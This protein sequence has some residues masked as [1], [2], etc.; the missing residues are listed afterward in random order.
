MGFTNRSHSFEQIDVCAEQ[1][2]PWLTE[3]AGGSGRWVRPRERGEEAGVVV[4]P[5]LGWGLANTPVEIPCGVPLAVSGGQCL[6][7][8]SCW[9]AVDFTAAVSFILKHLFSLSFL[10]TKMNPFSKIL[11]RVQTAEPSGVCGNQDGAAA[12]R[13]AHPPSAS[14]LAGLTVPIAV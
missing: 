3:G 6:L 7:M 8:C 14:V 9:D 5:Q 13:A 12:M 11:D 10:S 2:R 4:S 1:R